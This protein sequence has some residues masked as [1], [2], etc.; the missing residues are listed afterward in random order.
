MT[1]QTARQGPYQIRWVT[2]PHEGIT[3]CERTQ[4]NE[5][6]ILEENARKR[7]ILQNPLSGFRQ[8]LSIPAICMAE[9]SQKYPGLR[10]P[11]V[12]VRKRTMRRIQRDHP[13]WS[14]E[15]KRQR[16]HKGG[17]TR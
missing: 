7:E 4:L 14:T 1:E 3:Y 16:Y 13:E 17:L 11:D 12:S 15:T 5:R 6:L 8:V 9:V 2:Q 10:D